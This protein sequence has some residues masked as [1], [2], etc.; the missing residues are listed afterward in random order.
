M[1][2]GSAGAFGAGASAE[3]GVEVGAGV[4]VGAGAGVVAGASVTAGAGLALLL[5]ASDSELSALVTAPAVAET[6]STIAGETVEAL[7]PSSRHAASADM[8]SATSVA[9][10]L[11]LQVLVITPTSMMLSLAVGR[12]VRK[13]RV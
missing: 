12:L 5:K 6:D 2:A 13:Q 3:A 8:D 4:G 1:P 7:P 10:L 9:M 11:S